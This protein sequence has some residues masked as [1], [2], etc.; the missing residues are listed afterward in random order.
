MK[1]YDTAGRMIPGS[2]AFEY[3]GFLVS[4]STVFTPHEVRVFGCTDLTKQVAT[5][6]GHAHDTIPCAL[7][8]VDSVLGPE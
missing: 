8:W 4:A 1:I 2:C 7:R 3:R 6:D 5:E